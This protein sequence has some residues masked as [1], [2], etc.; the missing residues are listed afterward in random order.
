MPQSHIEKPM[1]NESSALMWVC[2][3]LKILFYSFY[4]I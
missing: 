3:I 2:E 1:M 4:E